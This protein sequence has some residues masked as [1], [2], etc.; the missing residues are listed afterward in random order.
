MAPCDRGVA[1]IESL[2]SSWHLRN[3]MN[4]DLVLGEFSLTLLKLLTMSLAK[5]CSL[6][7]RNLSIPPKMQRLIIRFHSD[8]IVKVNIGDKDVSFDSTTGVK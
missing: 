1:V 4:M 5:D 8:L 6:C 2:L 7:L 3:G